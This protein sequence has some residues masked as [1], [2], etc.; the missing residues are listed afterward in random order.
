M[1][2]EVGTK[3]TPEQAEFRQYCRQWLAQNTPPSA[4]V[5]LPQSALAIM[6]TDQLNYLSKRQ[7]A[8]YDAGL[9]A[10]EH[11]VE[12]GGRG[13]KDCQ[14]I[15][16]QEMQ[17]VATP[18]FPNVIGLGTAAPTVF[19]HAQKELKE[20]VLP[21]LFSGEEIWC[22]GFSK[23]GAGSDLSN[24]Q[25]FAEKKAMIGFT[26]ESYLHLHFKRQMHNQMLYGNAKY[27]HTKLEDILIG[28]VAA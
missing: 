25:T 11:P 13:R 22:Q 28:P 10:C 24:I 8:A 9:V 7:K 18:Y 16:N 15:A 6:T 4:S 26:W 5:R 21:K 20:P 17:S 19:F 3:D 1:S 23:P 12:C 14:M 27:Q 2:S